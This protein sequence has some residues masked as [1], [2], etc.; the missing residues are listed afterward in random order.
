MST[1]KLSNDR[2]SCLRTNPFALIQYRPVYDGIVYEPKNCQIRFVCC[3]FASWPF[4]L[5]PCAL[6]KLDFFASRLSF[7]SPE[8]RG[9][10]SRLP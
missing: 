8:T 4:S 10:V 5:R 6:R 1:I 3:T 2:F 7:V 9:L